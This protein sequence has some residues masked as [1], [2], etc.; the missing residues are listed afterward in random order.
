[1]PLKNI[2]TNKKMVKRQTLT[3]L[4]AEKKESPIENTCRSSAV[5]V[6]IIAETKTR[7]N[8]QHSIGRIIKLTIIV[9]NV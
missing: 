7:N 8:S 9:I 3:K 1:M 6:N 4:N 5:R 2:T